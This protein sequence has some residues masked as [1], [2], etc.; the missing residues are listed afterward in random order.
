MTAGFLRVSY[1]RRDKM[2][3]QMFLRYVSVAAL[4]AV[5]GFGVS[6]VAV[7]GEFTGDVNVLLGQKVL[8]QN[9]WEPLDTQ[10]ALGAEITWGDSSW[11]I[12]IATDILYST[13]SKDDVD[14]VDL[15]GS[16]MEF[17]LGIREVKNTD[18]FNYY[19]GLGFGLVSAHAEA[20]GSGSKIDDSDTGISGWG[21][22]GIFWRLGSRF[23]VGLAAR[24]SVANVTL[25]D[26]DVRA[27][28]FQYGV[29]VGW[30]WPAS[31]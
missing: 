14:G 10:P 5:V 11:P 12:S 29:I 18:N 27:G 2:P 24:Y 4:L 20:K 8:N 23:N 17:D 13:E 6:A 9:D 25:F 26:E 19:I 15:E 31:R 28:G 22:G 21:G 1:L 7:G 16:T 30:G 3:R